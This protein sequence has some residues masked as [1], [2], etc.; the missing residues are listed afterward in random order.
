MTMDELISVRLSGHD[1]R[2]P[3]AP[4]A[5][6]KLVR[7][8]EDARA[9]LSG[10]GDRDE[11]VA[12]L[13]SAIGDRLAALGVDPITGPQMEAV[14]AEVG[15][16]RSDRGPAHRT[17][18]PPRGRFW[19][20][21]K[22]GSWFGGICLGIAAHGEFRVDWVRTVILLLTLATGGFLGIVYLGLLLVL[23]VVPDM[24]EY[25]RRRAAPAGIAM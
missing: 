5:R 4:E 16:V 11:I 10:D 21:I 25:A 22:E 13:E 9:A 20:R 1:D 12:D 23:P 8:L 7:Y 19:C 24:A 6:G 14:L 15:L 2:F 3:L 17:T 18:G